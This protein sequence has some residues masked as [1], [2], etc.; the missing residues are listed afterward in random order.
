MT[1]DIDVLRAASL[2]IN[3]HGENAS[4]QAAMRHDE[5]LA[6]GDVEGAIVWKRILRAID[7]IGRKKR[8][9][10]EELN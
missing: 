10:D 8:R 2:L 7:E 4:L 1:S 9:P 3:R 5:L 6:N